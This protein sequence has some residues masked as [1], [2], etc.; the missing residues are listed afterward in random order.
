MQ[1]KEDSFEFRLMFSRIFHVCGFPEDFRFVIYYKQSPSSCFSRN[2]RWWVQIRTGRQGRVAHIFN[3]SPWEAEVSGSEFE[4][5]LTSPSE[6][7]KSQGETD[8]PCLKNTKAK[9]T[10]SHTHTHT[11]Q[12]KKQKQKQNKKISYNLICL[13]FF[14]LLQFLHLNAVLHY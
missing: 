7:K 9:H 3:P 2:I 11:P 6:F 12:N 10:H 4:D 5:N 1:F 14:S 8:K 13:F